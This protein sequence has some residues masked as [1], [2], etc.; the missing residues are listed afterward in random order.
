MGSPMLVQARGISKSYGPVAALGPIDLD[1]PAGS[2]G[3]VGPNGAGKTTM[4]RLLLGL[5]RPDAGSVRVLGVDTS[6][7]PLEV[8]ARVGYMPE[9]ECLIPE[10]TGV[11]FVSY[12]GR[13]SGLSAST[14]LSRA[15]DVLQFVGF[16]EERYRRISEYSMGM[17]Q[18]VKLAQAIV[19]DPPLCLLDEPT[20][21]LDPQGR[22]EMLG[23]LRELTKRT[24]KS[25]L[26]STHILSDVEGICDHLLVLDGG[27]AL[28]QGPIKDLLS[29]GDSS[30]VV[31]VKGDPSRFLAALASRG[32]RAERT[33]PEIRL[34]RP[35]GGERE[36]FEI[37]LETKSQV[38]HLGRSLQ[39]VED[40]FLELVRKNGAPPG[41]GGPSP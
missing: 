21:G 40:L 37:A 15:H 30:L 28:A 24:G 9:H 19:H 38:R 7:H 2:I 8:R 1:I 39:S 20:A 29:L 27:R 5:V 32:I 34:A 3:L 26:L 4:L 16:R 13:L 22:E 36:V 23:L 25:L 12:M 31:Q 33:G 41:P 10:M 17:R 6:A 18:R 14:A 35:P 11:G